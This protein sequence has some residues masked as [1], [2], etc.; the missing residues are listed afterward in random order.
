MVL[1][2]SLGMLTWKHMPATMQHAVAQSTRPG[3]NNQG[4]TLFWNAATS[5]EQ[6]VLVEAVENW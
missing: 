4:E 5:D 1:T 3:S 2:H 6:A